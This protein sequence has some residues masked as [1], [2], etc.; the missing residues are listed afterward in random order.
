MLRLI[1][2]KNNMPTNCYISN[3]GTANP[4]YKLDQE[5]IVPVISHILGLNKQRTAVLENVYKNS[6]IK[7]R[8]SVLADYNRKI[9]EFE[10]FSNKDDG[11]FPTTAQRMKI[12]EAE[13]IKIGIAAVKQCLPNLD[14]MK[15]SITHLITVSCTGMYTPGLDIDLMTILKLN[16]DVQRFCINFMGCYGAFPALRLAD[17]ICRSNPKAKVLLVAVELC[18]LHVQKTES[19]ENIVSSSLYSDGAAAVLIESTLPQHPCIMIENFYTAVAKDSLQ[20][21]TYNIGD[22]G[23]YM[24]LSGKVPEIISKGAN[25][26]VSML[27][28]HTNVNLSEVDLFAI[29]PGGKRV[30]EACEKAFNIP[31]SANVDSYNIL[32]NYGNMS[33]ATVLFVL[34]EILSK[35]SNTHHNQTLISMSFGPGLTLESMFARVLTA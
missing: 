3:I 16:A 30:L 29:H 28:Q 13:A 24:Y 8:Y 6:A 9:G 31:A 32:K 27:L 18:S 35:L 19:V 34:K 17:A 25:N 20:H 26:L 12:Y 10:F 11:V 33:S 5:K 21:M 7:N 22:Y 2:F 1:N 15:S 14:E 23:F 4:S